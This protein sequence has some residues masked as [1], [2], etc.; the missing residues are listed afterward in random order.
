VGVDVGVVD[1]SSRR[2]SFALRN[3]ANLAFFL[4]S[5][6]AALI[7]YGGD[8]VQNKICCLRSTV[9][10]FE[11]IYGAEKDWT[12][13]SKFSQLAQ[14]IMQPPPLLFFSANVLILGSLNSFNEGDHC[15]SSSHAGIFPKPS[16]HLT[17]VKIKNPQKGWAG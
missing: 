11:R 5:S 3:S 1:A 6:S 8:D 13:T 9:L 14:S 12:V 7:F 2:S 17:L 10:S 16:A 15:T 4:A